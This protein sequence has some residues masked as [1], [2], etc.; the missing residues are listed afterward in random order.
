MSGHTNI[1]SEPIDHIKPLTSQT[2]VLWLCWMIS[3]LYTVM[4]RLAKGTT[5]NHAAKNI[6]KFGANAIPRNNGII[7]IWM[8]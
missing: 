5:A 1:V 4:A 7:A 3:L 6:H 2:S 8:M